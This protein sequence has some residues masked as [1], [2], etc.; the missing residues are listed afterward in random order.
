M[1]PYLETADT[2]LRR[3]ATITSQA[4]RFHRQSTRPT[5]S[6]F[7]QLTRGLFQGRHSRL[8]NVGASTEERDRTS[9]PV[10]CFESEIRQVLDNLVTNAIDA[11]NGRGGK[12]YVRGRD[13]TDWK[14]GRF[15]MVLTCADTGSGMSA[16]T[17][18]KLFD[19]FFTTK[20]VGGTGL[21][22]WVSSEIVAH[23]GGRVSLRSRQDRGTVFSI[24]LPHD[25]VPRT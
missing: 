21:G 9:V 16:A 2:E 10:M 1:R 20:G 22:L 24:F 5:L 11:L 18:K 19:A 8:N 6:T 17:Q 12:L 4:L 3:A 7:Q 13:G 15:G 25:A 23:H 14:T